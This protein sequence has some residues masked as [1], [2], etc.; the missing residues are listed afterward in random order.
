MAK[1][2]KG[3]WLHSIPSLKGKSGIERFVRRYADAGFELLIPCVK[4]IDGL[5]DFHSR[6]GR[7]R[8]E[9]QAWDPLA[10]M[11]QVARQAGI[12]I[13]A[14]FCNTPEGATGKLLASHPEYVALTPEG[15][16][17][18][19]HKGFFTCLARP[20]VRNYQYRI[21]AELVGDYDIDGIHLDYIRIGEN[22][23]YCPICRAAYR[24]LMRKDLEGAEGWPPRA[25][26]WHRWRVDNVTKLVARI[27]KKCRESGKELSAAV[28]RDYPGSIVTQGQDFVKWSRQGLLDLTIPMN[29]DVNLNIMAGWT[30]NHLANMPD[31]T[32]MWEGLGHFVLR[33]TGQLVEQV[34][35]VKDLG[36]PGVV[37][38]EHHSITAKDLK[39]LACI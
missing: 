1:M 29:Y 38:F 9:S 15:E 30:R 6:I 39:A 12:K 20:P 18:P 17:A 28:F 37:I 25:V 14:W 32:E 22:A 27:S 34:Q 2:K 10:Y 16:P 11:A 21:M 31:E 13:H 26:A 33:G 24:R 7:V 3:V 8:P 5:L 4:N 35:C 19:C 23:C 36:V